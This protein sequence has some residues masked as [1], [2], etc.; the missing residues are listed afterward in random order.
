MLGVGCTPGDIF[1]QLQ[2]IFR[3]APVPGIYKTTG[4]DIGTQSA[5]KV[6]D[7]ASSF[8]HYRNSFFELVKI[9]D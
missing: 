6:T 7:R 8:G 4:I 2:K 9:G 1:Q 5:Y 3:P